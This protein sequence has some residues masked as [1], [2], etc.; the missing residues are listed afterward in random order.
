VS[1]GERETRETEAAPVLSLI[2]YT[3]R[4]YRGK[5]EKGGRGTRVKVRR[6]REGEGGKEGERTDQGL[7]LSACPVRRGGWRPCRLRR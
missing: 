4:R 6:E 2:Y 1:G 5:T 7:R 3:R